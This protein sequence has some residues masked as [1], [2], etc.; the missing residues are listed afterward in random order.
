MAV[1][2]QVVT[3][4]DSQLIVRPSVDQHLPHAAPVHRAIVTVGE[5]VTIV[6]SEL[7]EPKRNKG[8]YELCS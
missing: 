1:E 7:V 2:V 6:A 8:L 4:L 3:M 5:A